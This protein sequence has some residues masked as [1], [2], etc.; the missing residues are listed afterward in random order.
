MVEIKDNSVN[1]FRYNITSRERYPIRDLTSMKPL[2]RKQYFETRAPFNF[3]GLI[4]SPTGIMVGISVLMLLCMKNMPSQD[5]IKKMQQ[6][7]KPIDNTP[8]IKK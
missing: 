2:G 7:D 6:T 4:K 1:Y 8:T 3:E 5:E